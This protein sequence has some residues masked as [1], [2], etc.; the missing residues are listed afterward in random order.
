MDAAAG[1]RVTV[2]APQ[3]A[4]AALKIATRVDFPTA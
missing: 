4:N 2:G 3:G 1:P